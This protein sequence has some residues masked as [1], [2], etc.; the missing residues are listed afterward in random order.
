MAGLAFGF[1]L[2]GRPDI[3][4]NVLVSQA[5]KSWCR[6]WAVDDG[7]RLVSFQILQDLGDS[8]S[9]LC[10]L[11]FEEVLFRL[12]FSKAFFGALWVGEVVSGIL[13]AKLKN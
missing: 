7:R 1:K 13:V 10:T 9:R 6:R 5:L 8:F 11:F 2:R 3:T 4:K 12:P